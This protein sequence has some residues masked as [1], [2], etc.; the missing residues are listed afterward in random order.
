[1]MEVVVQVVDSMNVRVLTPK[2]NLH[3]KYLQTCSTENENDGGSFI[4]RIVL[5]PCYLELN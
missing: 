5:R 1:M 3:S 4:Q 2:G